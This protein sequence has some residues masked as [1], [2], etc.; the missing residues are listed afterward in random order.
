[1]ATSITTNHNRNLGNGQTGNLNHN[2]R[3]LIS[4]N[5]DSRLIENNIIFKSITL[6]EAYDEAFGNAVDE[7]N[8][9]QKRKDRRK[10]DR[11]G[12]FKHLFGVEP[13]N[14]SAQVILTS[15]ARGKHEIKSFNEEIYQVGDC[16]EFGH[17]VRDKFEK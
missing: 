14:E 1:M 12:Y 17:F 11:K 10:Y 13:E 9:R 2:R 8:H 5:V 7:Y 15:N 4:Q 6:A 16:Q 3:D